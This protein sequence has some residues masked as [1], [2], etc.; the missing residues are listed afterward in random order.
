M[1]IPPPNA[2]AQD[3]LDTRNFRTKAQ[4]AIRAGLNDQVPDDQ[5]RELDMQLHAAGLDLDWTSAAGQRVLDAEKQKQS[6]SGGRVVR[7]RADG[8]FDTGP[9]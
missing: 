5:L 1:F 2:T 7:P 3:I 9:Q 8:G 4:R 6:T